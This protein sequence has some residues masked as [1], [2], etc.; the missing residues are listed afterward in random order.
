MKQNPAQE[1]ADSRKEILERL[2][3]ENEA[4]IKRLKELEEAGVKTEGQQNPNGEDLVP[5]ESWEVINKEKEELQ[6]ELQAKEKRM[7]RLQQVCLALT[8]LSAPFLFGSRS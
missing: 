8:V 6:Q 4:L 7:L 2:K 3:S 5:R 1:W